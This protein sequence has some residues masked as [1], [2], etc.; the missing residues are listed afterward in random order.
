MYRLL[1]VVV[2]ALALAGCVKTYRDTTNLFAKGFYNSNATK[3]F[4]GDA[5]PFGQ[6][7]AVKQYPDGTSDHYFIYKKRWQM[8]QGYVKKVTPLFL[9]CLSRRPK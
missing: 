9:S 3:S 6:C 7:Y 2:L 8:E 1:V 4:S 5:F